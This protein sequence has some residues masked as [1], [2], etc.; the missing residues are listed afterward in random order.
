MTANSTLT[1]NFFGLNIQVER[2]APLTWNAL[3][4]S[5]TDVRFAHPKALRLMSSPEAKAELKR[6]GLK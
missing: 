4:A 1:F 5:C 2:S 6:R 3:A